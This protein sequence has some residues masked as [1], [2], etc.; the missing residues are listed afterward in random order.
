M[1]EYG[2]SAG[3]IYIDPV[4]L[5][6]VQN[7]MV[8]YFDWYGK[9]LAKFPRFKEDQK[10]SKFMFDEEFPGV[11]NTKLVLSND[12]SDI[13]KNFTEFYRIFLQIPTQLAFTDRIHL[14]LEPFDKI[15]F[16]KMKHRFKQ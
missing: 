13:Y 5:K 6:S 12:I 1:G 8:N 15:K 7:Q 16:R 11:L 4:K 3:N 10:T 14:F 9:D 2:F